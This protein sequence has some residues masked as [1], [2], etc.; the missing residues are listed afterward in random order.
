MDMSFEVIRG[1]TPG[2]EWRFPVLRFRPE[3]PTSGPKVYLQAG[4]HAGELPGP[5][6]LHLLAG[7]LRRARADGR[8]LS[9]ITLVP[10]ANPIGLNQDLFGGLQG[11]FDLATRTNFNR[12]FPLPDKPL[13]EHRALGAVARLKARLLEL[14]SGADIVLDLHCD[15]VS[16]QYAYVPAVLWPAMTDLAQALDC[17]AVLVWEDGSDGAFEE[18]ALA[19]LLTLPADELTTKVV[20]TVELRGLADVGADLAEKD[21]AGLM[22]FLEGR[23]ALAGGW[24]PDKTWSGLAVPLHNIEMVRSPIGGTV[25][26]DVIPGDKVTEGQ[27][28][29]RVLHAPGEEN[30]VTEV[31]APQAGTVIT[32]VS[33]QLVRPGGDL[34]KLAGL[35]PSRNFRPGALE[36]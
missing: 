34:V 3:G 25:W 9:E 13:P 29:A 32:R 27:R 19:P 6:V 4:L 35:V 30:G 31:H 24:R 21:A 23:G 26:F 15:D 2:L 5:G 1:D 11:R 17:A 12:C 7:H 22:R 8:L 10:M 18:A 36:S 16:L 33:Q 28:L 14:A 20:S